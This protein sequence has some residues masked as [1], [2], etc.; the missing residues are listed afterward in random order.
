MFASVFLPVLMLHTI[1]GLC[2]LPSFSSPFPSRFPFPRYAGVSSVFILPSLLLPL[3]SLCPRRNTSLPPFLPRGVLAESSQSPRGLSRLL[4]FLHIHASL[5]SAF[6][7]GD[8]SASHAHRMSAP[9]RPGIAVRS[10]LG[11]YGPRHDFRSTSTATGRA[12]LAPRLTAAAAQL[13]QTS[14]SVLGSQ[15][16]AGSRLLECFARPRR[17]V[18]LLVMLRRA[19]CTST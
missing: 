15:G 6:T 11:G 18:R 1:C 12:R 8:T 9:P 17:F 19:G 16:S 14:L 3:H 7:R 5:F 10:V 4:L 2:S 13:L